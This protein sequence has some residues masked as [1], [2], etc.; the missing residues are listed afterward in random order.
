MVM[1]IHL[2][3][4]GVR[5]W[6]SGGDGG[7]LWKQI[8]QLA[9]ADDW[10]GCFERG[11]E[12]KKAWALWSVWEQATG[13]RLGIKMELKTVLSARCLLAG[14]GGVRPPGGGARRSRRPSGPVHVA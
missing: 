10:L 5:V 11:E 6:G 4:K 2:H 1:A 7:D 9:Y 3:V 8:V 12:V 14:R 13:N